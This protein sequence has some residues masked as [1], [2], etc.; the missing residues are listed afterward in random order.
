MKMM[1]MV[2][3]VVYVVDVMMLNVCMKM[4]SAFN[5]RHTRRNCI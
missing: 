1:V 2:A 3:V 4:A 5:L